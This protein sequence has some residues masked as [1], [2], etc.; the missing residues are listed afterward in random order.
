MARKK[1]AFYLRLC[2]ALVLATFALIS[3]ITLVEGRADTKSRKRRNQ[4]ESESSPERIKKA[5]LLTAGLFFL[6]IAPLVL[7]FVHAI[8]TDP[9]IPLLW[10]EGITRGRTF[11]SEKLCLMKVGRKK[12]NVSSL[13][14]D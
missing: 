9:V 5:L 4:R 8:I 6:A 11:L 12:R 13:K 14:E 7:R 3:Y 10:K 1:H 2:Q